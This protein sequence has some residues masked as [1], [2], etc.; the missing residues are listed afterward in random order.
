MRGAPREEIKSR[1]L[2]T[3]KAL[4]LEDLLGRKPRQLSGGQRQ[5]V[6]LG[7]AI[8]R[9]PAAFLFDEPLSNLDARLRVL[10]RSELRRLHRRFPI[11][12]LHVTHDQEE[13]MTLGDRIVVMKDGVIQQADAPMDVYHRPCNRFVAGFIGTPS[14]NFFEGV[15]ESTGDGLTFREIPASSA[16]QLTSADKRLTLWI[17]PDLAGSAGVAWLSRFGGNRVVLGVRPENLQVHWNE[18][19]R[20]TSLEARVDMIEHLGHSMDVG[21]VTA[22]GGRAAARLEA[23][24]EVRIGDK[25]F[26]SVDPRGVHVFE[27]GEA[28]LN[29]TTETSMSSP[30]RN[31][32]T[33]AI[34]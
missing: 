9:R 6:A 33:H 28:G 30:N 23:R 29:L 34:A 14:M 17:P 11:T 15:L 4:D 19:D 31:E 1:V 22:C 20:P 32:P 7:R 16:D 12:T 10:M 18:A 5:R 21:F 26:L 25:A 13:A 2:E 27:P 3:A 24:R 8:V